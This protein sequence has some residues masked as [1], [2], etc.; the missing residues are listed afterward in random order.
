[1]L[2]EEGGMTNGSLQCLTS[3]SL[4]IVLKIPKIK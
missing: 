3:F 2:N 1:M 4:D